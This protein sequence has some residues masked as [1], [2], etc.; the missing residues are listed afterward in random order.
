MV[1]VILVVDADI[2]SGEVG[3]VPPRSLERSRKED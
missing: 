3:A 2:D 1:A